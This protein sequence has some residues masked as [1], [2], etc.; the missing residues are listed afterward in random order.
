MYFTSRKIKDD[1]LSGY[2]N[3]KIQQSQLANQRLI[4]ECHMAIH[5]DLQGHILIS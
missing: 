2:N 5:D 3:C 1:G 4:V